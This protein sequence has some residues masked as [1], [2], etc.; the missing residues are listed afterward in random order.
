M[1]QFDPD[2]NIQY[3][4]GSHMNLFVLYIPFDGH[5]EVYKGNFYAC[6]PTRCV[7]IIEEGLN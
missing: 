5:G 6:K 2:F 7:S 1:K 3:S 4:C